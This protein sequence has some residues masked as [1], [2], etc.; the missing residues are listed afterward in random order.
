MIVTVTPNPSVDRTL[1]V[2]RVRPGLVIRATSARVD[3]GGKGVNVARALVANGHRALAVVPLGGAD[4][5]LLEGLVAEAGIPCRAVPTAATTRSNITLSEPDGTVTKINAPGQPLSDSELHA[6]LE[7]TEAVLAGATWLVGCGSLPDGAPVD[8]YATLTDR[9]HAAGVAVAVD[10]SGPPLEAAVSARPD[11]LKPNLAE[12]VQLVGRPLPT[13]DDVVA[14]AEEVR[15]DGP[16]ALVVSLGARGAVL[17]DG[18]E[19]LLAVPPPV[20]ARSDVGA[21]D[22]LLAGFLAAGGAGPLS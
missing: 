16:R 13:V 9:A 15:Q 12:L 7:T 18:D 20:A 3:A 21:G 11:V 1:E 6:L 4:G 22:T 8:L 14:A 10:S 19:P 17:V 2:D 5:Q